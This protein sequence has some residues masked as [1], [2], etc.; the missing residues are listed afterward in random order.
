MTDRPHAPDLLAEPAPLGWNATLRQTQVRQTLF[1]EIGTS[2]RSKITQQKNNQAV[3][4]LVIPSP[5]GL[6]AILCVADIGSNSELQILTSSKAVRAL[7]AWTATNWISDMAESV[8]AMNRWLQEL[9]RDRQARTGFSCISYEMPNLFFSNIGD[10]RVYYISDRVC[11]SLTDEHRLLTAPLRGDSSVSRPGNGRRNA[12]TSSRGEKL[13][14]GCVCTNE[15]FGPIRMQHGD[16][17]VLCSEGVWSK[18]DPLKIS[19]IICA[20]NAQQGAETLTE[21]S[22]VRDGSKDVSAIVM[23]V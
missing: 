15:S 7:L 3:G 22:L 9:S 16:A 8:G 4:V 11:H 1:P 20:R 14:A 6:R 18:L 10:T 23:V 17:L 19:E 2:S 21:I 13:D 12:L 5:L